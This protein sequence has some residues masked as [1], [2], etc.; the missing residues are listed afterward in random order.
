MSKTEKLPVMHFNNQRAWEEWLKKNHSLSPGIKM[1]IAK[2]GAEVGSATYAEALETAL[3]YGWI[4]SR[5]EALDD[6]F[7]IQRFTPRGP[8]SI[9][10]KIN[11]E[12]AEQL[13]KAGKMLPAGQQ[14]IENAKKNGQWEKAYESQSNK[15]IPEDL[16]AAL[17]KNP[18]AKAFFETLN[19][20]NRYAIIFRIGKVKKQET[21]QRKI[22]QFLE[23]LEKGEKIHP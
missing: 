13:I 17:N 11:R 22:A 2:K 5:K 6:R 16:E 8:Q 1:K 19:S 20:V 15:K 10:S 21:R 4:D 14:A 9:W 12:K 23:M 7:W 18:K 3:C